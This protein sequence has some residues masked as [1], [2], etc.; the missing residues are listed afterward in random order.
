LDARRALEWDPARAVAV[1]LTGPTTVVV[2]GDLSTYNGV[3]CEYPTADG[4]KLTIL[5]PG[6]Q[7][8]PDAVGG[9]A[10]CYLLKLDVPP[11][12]EY[13]IAAPNVTL[14]FNGSPRALG[15]QHV[16]VVPADEG[17]DLYAPT[18][19]GG[20]PTP[21]YLLG[22]TSATNGPRPYT[23]LLWLH[24]TPYGY[25]DNQIHVLYEALGTGDTAYGWSEGLEGS[26][27]FLLDSTGGAADNGGGWT[28]YEDY[29]D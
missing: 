10:Y 8:L 5:R 6:S 12:P 17:L 16:T 3:I 18:G 19:H 21:W 20:N 7:G 29:Y 13:Q 2:S 28:V 23:R 14:S 26:R 27:L 25:P 15:A 1:Q 11:A 4:R 22:E 24:Q 9:T